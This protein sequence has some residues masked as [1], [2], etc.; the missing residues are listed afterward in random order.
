MKKSVIIFCF[1]FLSTSIFAHT[2]EL[3]FNIKNS[4]GTLVS[5]FTVGIYSMNAATGAFELVQNIT[6]EDHGHSAGEYN[7]ACDIQLPDG[8]IYTQSTDPTATVPWVRYLIIKFGT[9]YIRCDES[10][11]TPPDNRCGD[12]Y[13][14]YITDTASLSVIANPSYWSTIGIYNWSDSYAFTLQNSFSSGT[15]K[16][17]TTDYNHNTTLTRLDGSFPHT[18]SPTHDG[19][20]VSNYERKFRNW[21]LPVST[22][23]VTEHSLTMNNLSSRTSGIVRAIMLQNVI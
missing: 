23:T 7:I 3:L 15:V 2:Y 16:L 19:Q 4:Q 1:I 17:R 22:S 9:K 6:S 18:I 21:T 20:V 13:L 12:M 8:T 10:Y 14:E 5:G 11:D